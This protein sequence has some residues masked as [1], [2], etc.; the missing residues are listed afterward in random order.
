MSDRSISGWSLTLDDSDDNEPSPGPPVVVTRRYDA[1]A[2]SDC[3]LL[4]L[5]L[6][7]LDCLSA[8]PG[9]IGTLQAQ[10]DGEGDE[11]LEDSEQKERQE[12]SPRRCV[13]SLFD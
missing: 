11:A 12:S 13:P 1:I 10:A 2:T 7:S 9:A 4:S 6:T 3:K 5:S 8:Q